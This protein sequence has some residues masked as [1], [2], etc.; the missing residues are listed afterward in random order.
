[1]AGCLQASCGLMTSPGIPDM[2]KFLTHQ[3]SLPILEIYFNFI[4]TIV[5]TI[6]QIR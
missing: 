5:N 6:W 2:Q 3:I 4:F 1:V